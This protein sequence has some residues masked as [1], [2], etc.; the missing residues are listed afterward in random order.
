MMGEILNILVARKKGEKTQP[1]TGV[2]EKGRQVIRHM[3]SNVGTITSKAWSVL[4][5]LLDEANLLNQF[6]YQ[7]VYSNPLSGVSLNPSVGG[8]SASASP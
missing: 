1:S 7:T 2:A 5:S 4:K 6:L 8:A 3:S